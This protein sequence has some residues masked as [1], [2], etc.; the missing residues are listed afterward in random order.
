MTGASFAQIESALRAEAEAASLAHMATVALRRIRAEAEAFLLA[1]IA[2]LVAARGAASEA[3]RIRAMLIDAT[4][5]EAMAQAPVAPA[6]GPMQL[7]V[8]YELTRGGI[9]KPVG[10]HWQGMDPLSVMCRQA[11]ARYDRDPPRNARGEALAFIPPFTPGQI[12]MA[13]HYAALVERHDCGGMKGASVEVRAVAS[14]GTGQGGGY[15]EA[16]LSDGREIAMIR[17]RIGDGLALEVQRGG[18]RRRSIPVRVLVDMVVL[19]GADLTAVLR[20]HGWAA[21]GELRQQMQ[22]ALANALDRMQGYPQK[23]S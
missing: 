20:A 8:D 10:Q 5:P 3:D 14:A 17:R 22:K 13:L 16:L 23:A 18:D 15:I 11:R 1:G 12:A 4:P 2:R 19:G 21:K 6:R 7:V 9:P